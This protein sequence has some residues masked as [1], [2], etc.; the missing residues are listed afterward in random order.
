MVSL[1]KILPQK[2]IL[3]KK[4]ALFCESQCFR[5]PG[6]SRFYLF[7]EL[8]AHLS[9]SVIDYQ[10]LETALEHLRESYT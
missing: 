8:M 7:A 5:Q 10:Q 9:C 1:L 3:K 6:I 2:I 4:I